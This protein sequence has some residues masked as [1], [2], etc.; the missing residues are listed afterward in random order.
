M[1]LEMKFVEIPVEGGPGHPGLVVKTLHLRVKDKH[2]KVLTAMAYEVNTVWNYLNELSHRS[3]VERHKWLNRYDF[4]PYTVGYTKCEGVKI[5]TTT[6]QQISEEY[7]TRR[8]Q[9]KKI[10]LNWRVS[11]PKSP[12]YSLGWIPFKS[13][14]LIYSLGQ[15][16]FAGLNLGL[17][18]SYDLSKYEL[19]SGSFNQDNK[20]RWYLNVVVHV[21]TKASTGTTSIGI[22]LGLKECAVT[23]D[24][25]RIE[26]RFYRKSEA[27]LGIAQRACKKRQ[28]KTIHAKIKNQRKDLLHKFSTKLVAEN[29]AI[30]V[31]NVSSQKMV[32]TRMAKS[33]LDAG[34]AI[35]KTM[36]LYKSHQAGVIYEEVNE[37]YT[38]QT[39]SQCG[40][41][42]GPKGIAGLVKREWTCS[43]CGTVHDRDTNAARNILRIGHD[44]LAVGASAS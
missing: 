2:A 27:K 8:N 34:W 40:S 44:T 4:H 43:S 25:Q 29:A 26:G 1:A 21:K 13:R 32:K 12:K 5:G 23:S 3:I 37:S 41:I 22:D 15:V 16:R 9:F 28:V 39:C 6:V 14:G 31:G 30:F 33:T 18:D 24:G 42:E 38:T 36:I 10:K 35:F 19:R 20:G 17:W 7:A 11:N